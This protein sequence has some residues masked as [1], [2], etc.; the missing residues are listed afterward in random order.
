MQNRETLEEYARTLAFNLGQTERDYLQHIILQT[1]SENAGNQMVFK[2]GTSLQKT[3][4]MPR[5][6]EDL[7]FTVKIIDTKELCERITE[8]LKYYGYESNPRKTI[9]DTGETIVFKI[10]GP[11]YNGESITEASVRLDLSSRETVILKAKTHT[12]NPVYNDIPQYDINTM[13]E[14]EILAEK[15]R[16]MTKRK[17]ARDLYD[18][19]HLL[20]KNVKLDK[21]L[22]T[23]KLKYY[24]EKIDLEKIE[25]AIK[26]MQ[27]QWAVEMKILT[28]DTPEYDTVAAFTIK[29]IKEELG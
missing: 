15:I 9:Q 27:K 6:S 7:D 2:G 18:I 12:I 17:R 24:N 28:R 1:V 26:N 14:Q 20:G 19:N 29:K 16:A 13:D 25:E 21:N 22:V 4:N 10:H 8:K 5:Y 3:M 23:E 11:L